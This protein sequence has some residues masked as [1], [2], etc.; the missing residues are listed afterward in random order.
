MQID[1]WARICALGLV[2]AGCSSAP[3]VPTVDFGAGKPA[4]GFSHIHGLAVKNDGTLLAATHHGLVKLVGTDWVYASQD[5]VDHMGFSLDPKS[6][7]MWRSGH[8][9]TKPSIGVETSTDGGETWSHLSDVLSPPVDFHSM[10]V[11]SADGKTLWGNDSGRRGTFRSTDAGATWTKLP[12]NPAAYVMAGSATKGSLFAGVAQGLSRSDDG[13]E[14]WTPVTPLAGGWVIAVATDPSDAERVFAFSERG[15]KLSTDGGTT[16]DPSLGGLPP[17][18]K[19]LS[20]AVSP[21]DGS[22]VYA[23]DPTTIYVS[24]DGGKTWSVV[25][26]GA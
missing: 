22:I 11:S 16:W 1:R 4:D 26:A 2:L 23:A 20:I 25:R 13:G 3:D 24:K 18:A 8:S 9:S 15:M 7:V 12:E 19:I 5:R 21:A 17:T 10:T 6:G 14:T